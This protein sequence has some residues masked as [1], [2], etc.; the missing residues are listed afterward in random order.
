VKDTTDLPEVTECGG[1]G[2]RWF[3]MIELVSQCAM[4][5][6]LSWLSRSTF[7]GVLFDSD[8]NRTIRGSS[9]RSRR[10]RVVRC[11]TRSYPTPERLT[12]QR[13]S[14]RTMIAPIVWAIPTLDIDS[15]Q[16]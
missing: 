16:E 13:S 12:S 11:G 14:P 8:R 4:M 3:S 10:L 6:S 2:S 7:S 15:R 9:P 1:D 5:V